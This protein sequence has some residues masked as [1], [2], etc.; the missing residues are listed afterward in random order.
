MLIYAIAGA[1]AAGGADARLGAGS[2]HE[3]PYVKHSWQDVEEIWCG[4]LLAA[5]AGQWWSKEWGGAEHM[6]WPEAP[7]AWRAKGRH[8]WDGIVKAPVCWMDQASRNGFDT[9]VRCSCSYAGGLE[10][11]DQVI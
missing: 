6:A 3:R 7:D 4:V 5:A 11:G 8:Q 2:R 1:L 10:P 9:V